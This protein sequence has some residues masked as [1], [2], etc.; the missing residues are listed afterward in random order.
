PSDRI[1]ILSHKSNKL[2][3]YRKHKDFRHCSDSGHRRCLGRSDLPAARRRGK[4]DLVIVAGFSSKGRT[5]HLLQ[6]SWMVVFGNSASV[7]P[8][9]C[10]GKSPSTPNRRMQKLKKK[11]VLSEA[12]I[13][14]GVTNFQTCLQFL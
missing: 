2:R 8:D 12:K 11:S 4:P 7:F 6:E 10:S 9:E 3:H 13:P 14:A 5:S 1:G